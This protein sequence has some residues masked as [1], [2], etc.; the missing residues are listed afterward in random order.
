MSGDADWVS[1]NQRQFSAALDEVRRL[2]E[3]HLA[4]EGG[5]AAAARKPVLQ[6][7]TRPRAATA[8]SALETLC[9]RFALSSFERRILL[10]AAGM[11][12]DGRFR[13]LC[14][15]AGGPDGAPTFAL[16]LAAFDDAGWG[17][18]APTAP[19]RRWRLIEIGKGAALVHSPL[20]IDQAVVD[21][22][23]GQP[24]S[25]PRLLALAEP[26]PRAGTLAPSQLRLA[27]RI[28]HVWRS[29]ADALPIIQLVAAR[30]DSAGRAIAAAACDALGLGLTALSAAALPIAAD[31]LD[32]VL[33]LAE[34]HVMLGGGAV[35]LIA[36]APGEPEPAREAA[37]VRLI[38]CLDVPLIVTG[39][40]RRR[41]GLRPIL[42]FD[43]AKPTVAEQQAIWRAALGETVATLPA[44]RTFATQFQLEPGA[45]AAAC[46]DARARLALESPEA[47]PVAQALVAAVWDSCR[48]QAR[49]RLDDLA[50]RIE[51]SAD[52]DDLIL[53]EPQ[54]EVLRA[55]AAQVR[56]RGTVQQDWG[57]AAQ[58]ERGLGLAALFV[59][60]SGTG[61]T[62][63]AEVLARHLH[64]DLY[65]VDL[66]A[67]VSKY[68]GETEK[69]LR[70]VFDAAEEG[71]V[72]LLFDEADA[73]FGK[74][75]E[76]RDSHDRYANVEVSYL[77]Q[78]VEAYR[79][80]AILTTNMK[81]ALDSAFLRR[82]RFIVTFP[83]PDAAARARI[84]ESVF[85]PA[86]PRRGLD[87]ARLAQL[88]VS[89][90]QIRS[91]ALN[92]A[93]LAAEAGGPVTMAEILTAARHE[94]GKAEKTLTD[95]E[96]KGWAA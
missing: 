17:A 90:G 10:L 36:E 93:Y 63:A 35:L 83:F 12:L 66:S 20:R 31:D 49:P 57:F 84:W 1:Y 53:P 27:E 78:R 8:P 30:V 92:A 56:H 76:V 13:A 28:A 72:V 89:G 88:S 62:M 24:A 23:A 68:I 22:L 14:A 85:P 33:R 5:D 91:I 86:A 71:G 69:N 45:I 73:L 15:A 94:Y 87:L 52:W 19:L 59:G 32:T 34:R 37:I 9:D 96:L 6:P 38:E 41:G 47:E 81:E 79:G 61:K 40:R 74:R 2:I 39:G 67:V 25:E 60:S 18:L 3:R 54:R 51:V 75:T 70:R 46:A 21:F 44:A 11:E 42:S 26:L 95:T 4:A 43:V 16:A 7:P 55:I 65:R 82:L 29:S 48:M 77:L 50:Q 80:L 64:L 58:G